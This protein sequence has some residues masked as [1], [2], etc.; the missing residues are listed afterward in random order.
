MKKILTILSI[1]YMLFI[2]CTN[3]NKTDGDAQSSNSV[4]RTLTQLCNDLE[5]TCLDSTIHEI[6][7]AAML[8][9]DVLTDS[10]LLLSQND[11]DLE[12]VLWSRTMSGYLSEV[13]LTKSIDPQDQA[14]SEKIAQKLLETN[15][16][17]RED[18]DEEEFAFVYIAGFKIASYGETHGPVIDFSLWFD[19]ENG[20]KFKEIFVLLPDVY[21]RETA[22]HFYITFS[23]SEDGKYEI[24]DSIDSFKYALDDDGWVCNCR[25][26]V[27]DKFLQHRVAFL[28]CNDAAGRN[29]DLLIN[30]GWLKKQYK[31]RFEA[32]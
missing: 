16:K 6:S 1:A 25:E 2:S 13:F 8:D 7:H 10:L 26:D 21:D 3:T 27:F 23:D 28:H 15:F 11:D 30:L 18:E 32:E 31:E 9:I 5:K 17:F 29:D 12:S 20:G 14:L 24:C 22:P 4:N 19:K